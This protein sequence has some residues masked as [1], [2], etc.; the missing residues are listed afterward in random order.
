M[1]EQAKRTIA[2][3][4]NVVNL[5]SDHEA[6]RPELAFTVNRRVAMLLGVNTA[7]IG[8]FLKMAIF[9][10]KV[11]TYRQLND[12][13]DITVRLPVE[14]R[15]KIDDLYRLQIPNASG[16]AVPLSSLGQLKYRGGFGTIKRVNQKRVITLTADTE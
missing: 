2:N 4:P 6:R 16:Q 13:Y 7:T 10:S 12:E 5:R 15:R 14:D 1:S 9:G 3:V 8:N 11:G